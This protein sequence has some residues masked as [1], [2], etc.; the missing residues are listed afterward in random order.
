MCSLCAVMCQR[1]SLACSVMDRADTSCL[2]FR[3]IE[4]GATS[5]YAFITHGNYSFHLAT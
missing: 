1:R 2:V 3:L 4:A 5:V